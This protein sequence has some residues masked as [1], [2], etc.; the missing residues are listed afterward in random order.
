MVA[1]RTLNPKST[2]N[3]L[4]IPPYPSANCNNPSLIGLSF[5]NAKNA[6]YSI[7]RAQKLHFALFPPLIRHLHVI[8]PHMSLLPA[9]LR[10]HGVGPSFR[11][12]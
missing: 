3:L 5:R 10:D 2:N 1:Q 9:L 8:V 12:S 6:N 11:I 7:T 4:N